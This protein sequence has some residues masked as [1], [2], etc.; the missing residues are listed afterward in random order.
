[1]ACRLKAAGSPNYAN[2][3]QVALHEHALEIPLHWKQPRA[4]FVNSMSDL[5]HKD[6]PFDFI[7]RVFDVMRRAEQHV[8]QVLTKRAR[9]LATLAQRLDWPANV[10]MGVLLY[11]SGHQHRI[12]A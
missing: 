7:S 3:F 12:D 9:L 10:W 1:M 6:V 5:F 8:F 11:L 2:G 4:I